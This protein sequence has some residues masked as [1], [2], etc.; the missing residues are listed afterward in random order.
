MPKL[1]ANTVYMVL[2]SRIR[3]MGGRD[4]YT[5][6]NDL[7]I[8]STMIRDTNS[9][10]SQG[11]R[12]TDGMQGRAPIVAITK[13]VFNDDFEMGRMNVS[14]GGSFAFIETDFPPRTNLRAKPWGTLPRNC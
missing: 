9:Q 3:I 11:T 8:T 5:S 6:S 7:S 13:E 14:H 12:R 2:N 10:S 1:Y 4:T